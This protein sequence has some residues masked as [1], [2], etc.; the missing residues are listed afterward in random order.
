MI[1]KMKRVYLMYTR[2][3]QDE[4]I[5][6]LQKLGVLHIEEV[7]LPGE[8]DH[9]VEDGLADVR[10]DVENLLI[11]ARGILDLFA[12]VDSKLLQVSPAA[13]AEYP[14]R[15]ED[16]SQAFRE[17]LESLEGRLRMLVSERRELRERLEAI[18]RFR[19]V[20]HASEELLVDL[21]TEGRRLV[22]MI[23]EVGE[24]LI[25]EIERTLQ[26][27][28]AGRFTLRWKGLSEGRV[29]VLVSVEP[30]YAE[31]VQEYLEAKGLRR[32]A[33]PTHVGEDFQNGIAQLRAEETTLPQRLAELDDELQHIARQH[34]DRLVPLTAA[35][36]NRLAQLEA[37]LRF[38]YTDFALLVT[39]WVPTDE[40]ARF[41]ETLAREFPGIVMGEDPQPASHEEIPVAFANHPWARPYQLMLEVIGLPKYGSVDPIPFI[42]LFFPVF[43]GLI[44]GDV[45]YG[46]VLLGLA[47]FARRRWGKRSAALRGAFTIAAQAAG[48]SILFGV[49]FGEVFGFLMPWPHFDRLK[50]T[51]AFLIFSV[52]LGAV[53]IM[54]G[55]ILGVIGALRE[56][57][58]KHLLA[59]VGGILVLISL[60]MVVGTLVGLLPPELRTPGIALLAAALVMLIYGEGFIGLLEVFT[61]V[62][63]II[64]YA[65]IMGFGVA[66][67]VLAALVNE[68][69]GA[70]GNIVL[71]VLIGIVLHAFNLVLVTFES[72]IQAARL[73]FVEFFQKFLE[74]GG[75]QYEPFREVSA[76]SLREEEVL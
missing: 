63:H 52:A 16:L 49:I 60:G 68:A 67:V 58:R 62:G 31:A 53:H 69:A 61:Y 48:M 9:V 57:N 28:L 26:S 50:G 32:L 66:A 11:K 22:A 44:V 41:R 47:L 65:R 4:L 39:G 56:A 20:L 36:E 30:D 8:P 1:R 72:T 37:A 25:S 46:L 71:G 45:G 6:R 24:P 5:E 59:K 17:E 42:S 55:F 23:G 34:A 75:R 40:D 29:I 70:M 7:E 54:L 15:L 12:E 73:H 76:V 21:P 51:I 35:L 3:Q 19:E 33:L 18:E 43:F 13:K 74:V 64:S 14:T 38:G 27:Q 2:D 10:R